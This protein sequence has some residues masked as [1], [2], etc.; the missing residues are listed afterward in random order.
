MVKLPAVRG[1]FPH[2]TPGRNPILAARRGAIRTNTTLRPRTYRGRSFFN[3]LRR[4]G[5][6]LPDLAARMLAET[7][8][9]VPIVVEDAGTSTGAGPSASVNSTSPPKSGTS[10]SRP[11][12]QSAVPPN[13]GAGPNSKSP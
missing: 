5:L 11:A 10:G 6:T 1:I 2:H 9:P 4:H 3:R 12:L 13:I 7:T 8:L